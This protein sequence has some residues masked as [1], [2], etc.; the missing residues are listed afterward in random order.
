[1]NEK[2]REQRTEVEWH[3]EAFSNDRRIEGTVKNITLNGILVCCE[4]PLILDRN[5]RLSIFPP[6]H[7]AINVVGKPLWSD[8]DP[9]DLDEE[10]GPVCTGIVFVKISPSNLNF[11]KSILRSQI[12]NN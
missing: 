11:L 12:R 2:R 6:H 10:I 8:P 4:E 1:M 7:D 9:V 3:Y 5:Y